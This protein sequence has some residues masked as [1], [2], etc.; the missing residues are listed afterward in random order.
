MNFQ[1]PYTKSTLSVGNGLMIQAGDI[2][3]NGDRSIQE[4]GGGGTVIITATVTDQDP[5]VLE[6]YYGNK[7]N[8]NMVGLAANP[9]WNGFSAYLIYDVSGQL[10]LR[11]CG[12]IFKGAGEA[13]TC[14]DSQSGTRCRRNDSNTYGIHLHAPV[15]AFSVADNTG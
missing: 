13:N 2:Y 12:E 10:S 1:K 7:W 3:S 4:T 6:P 9:R 5:V 14:V 15:R 8:I 11:I